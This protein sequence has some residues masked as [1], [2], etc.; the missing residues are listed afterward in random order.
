LDSLINNPK[1]KFKT[2]K[3]FSGQKKDLERWSIT[4]LAKS[5]L[6]GYNDVLIGNEI[7]PT[8]GGKD[9]DAFLIKND[10]AYAKLLISCEDNLCFEL[11]HSSRSEQLPEGDAHVAWSNLMS[12]F[13]PKTKA[14]LI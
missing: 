6:R 2:K 9:F 3:A 1:R 4:F 5:R 14:N 13:E 10:V 11:V 8:K 12:N 7:V